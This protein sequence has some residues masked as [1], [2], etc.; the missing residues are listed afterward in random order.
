MTSV[1]VGSRLMTQTTVA[2]SRQPIASDSL[3]DDAISRAANHSELCSFLF[4]INRDQNSGSEDADPK[5]ENGRTTP[6]NQP[7]PPHHQTLTAANGVGA[8]CNDQQLPGLHQTIQLGVR[9]D[10]LRG[11]H[12][13]RV[14][15]APHACEGDVVRGVRSKSATSASELLGPQLRER[16]CLRL[17]A[18]PHRP[19]RY[20][21][22]L[23]PPGPQDGALRTSLALAS[24]RASPSG[25]RVPSPD[26]ARAR[27]EP[28]RACHHAS[29]AAA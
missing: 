16:S 7:E 18:A 2:L 1:L 12:A 23:A 6:R 8:R 14:R 9:P 13:R 22:A 4:E 28:P 19:R 24:T 27:P 25:P 10:H 17:R 5:D 20:P 29:M 3:T 26:P 21:P 11:G 15:G